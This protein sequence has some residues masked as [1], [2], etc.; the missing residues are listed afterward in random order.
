MRQSTKQIRYQRVLVREVPNPA[1]P[2]HTDNAWDD[3][4]FRTREEAEAEPVDESTFPVYSDGEGGTIR[5][6]VV[7]IASLQAH[8]G[9]A[10]HDGKPDTEWGVADVHVVEE[11]EDP[12]QRP[13]VGEGSYADRVALANPESAAVTAL[14]ADLAALQ[15]EME[16]EQIE[17]VYTPSK[18]AGTQGFMSS[19][20]SR[21]VEVPVAETNTEGEAEYGDEGAQ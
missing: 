18:G 17:P 7:E 6:E 5:V 3:R 10:I 9:L 14:K 4:S 12:V 15:A 16:A 20:T 8:E 21:L 11:Y 2:T 13:D 19:E 1:M